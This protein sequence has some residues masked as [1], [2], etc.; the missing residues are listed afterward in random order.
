[1]N[2]AAVAVRRLVLRRGAAALLGLAIAP[3]SRIAQVPGIESGGPQSPAH[4]EA[5]NRERGL[6]ADAVYR[7]RA[8]IYREN[9]LRSDSFYCQDPDLVVLASTTQSWRAGIMRERLKKQ[10][11]I[12]D[13]LDDRLNRIWRD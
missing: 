9:Q 6:L 2:L 13:G 10:Y 8:L 4:T 12:A 7:D 3:T 1:M 5:E 11:E